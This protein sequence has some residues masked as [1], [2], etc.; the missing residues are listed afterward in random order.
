MP[1]VRNLGPPD[2]GELIAFLE[3][4]VDTSL[5][6][7]SN[8]DAAGFEDHGRTLQGTYAGAFTNDAMTAVAV[9][10]WNGIVIVQGDAGLEDAARASVAHSKR[11]LSGLL[12]PLD[13]VA[14]A[15]RRRAPRANR[16]PRSPL[17][18]RAR[19][20]SGPRVAR[21]SRDRM[22]SAQPRRD[23]E[24]ARRL[25][26]RLFLEALGAERTPALREE[27]RESLARL[28]SRGWVLCHD[29]RQ[30]AYSTFNARTRGVVQVGGVF[31]PPEL[32]GRGYAR[33]VVAGSLLDA[34]REGNRRSVLF[35]PRE[36][37]AARRAY[38]ALGYQAIG[39]FG[40]VLLGGQ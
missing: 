26:R 20:A 39:E 5:F 38:E 19:R 32:R 27:A 24:S 34:R 22:P 36:N 18:A 37:V 4:R 33:A 23:R 16:R 3:Q 40:M 35:T 1:D 12:G 11:A 13:L 29:G 9:H 31:T 25:A 14:R 28:G 7:L 8:L 6:L 10:Y 21:S 17:R 15:R 30:V 2:R